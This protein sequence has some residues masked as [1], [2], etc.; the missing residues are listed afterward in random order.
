MDNGFDAFAEA[1]RAGIRRR[2]RRRAV[3]AVVGSVAVVAAMAGTGF[4]LARPSP[5]KTSTPAVATSSTAAEALFSCPE[6]HRVFTDPVPPISDLAEQ[7]ATI[8]SIE[9]TAWEGFTIERTAPSPLGVVAMVEGDLA[10]A[11]SALG[12]VGVQIVYDW[13]P[14]LDG[15]GMGYLDW[16][17]QWRLD[18]VVHE[19][20]EARRGIDGYAGVALWQEAG[21]VV[22]DWKAPIPPE[23]EALAGVRP[24]RVTVIVRPTD[25]SSRELAHARGLVMKAFDSGALS[26]RW[27]SLSSCPDAS[28]VV[29]GIQPPLSEE[30][31]AEL[32]YLLS[33]IAGIP[34]M[35]VPQEPA[36]AM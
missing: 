20:A 13:D 8:A 32:Q 35:V 27:T 11:R 31:R 36:V 9:A 21:A 3:V 18:A 2:Q 5:D 7:Q 17:I 24:D 33:T 22:L 29:V 6:L 14:Q 25:Y 34:V 23:I 1:L 16:V 15:G 28:G 12:A 10:G 19:L 4:V 30:R 26:G